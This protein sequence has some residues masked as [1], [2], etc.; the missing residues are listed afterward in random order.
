LICNILKEIF[1]LVNI[2]FLV[3]AIFRIF[4]D[5]NISLC[6]IIFITMGIELMINYHFV[7]RLLNI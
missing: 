7:V 2:F 4:V 1:I 6:R 5:N 3:L